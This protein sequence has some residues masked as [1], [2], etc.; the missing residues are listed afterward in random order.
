MCTSLSAHAHA[1]AAQLAKALHQVAID[2]GSWE[3]A[4]LMLPLPDAFQEP[5]FGGS[6]RELAAV[7][8]Y[9]KAMKDLRSKHARL[10]GSDDTEDEETT[11]G[12]AASKAAKKKAALAKKKAAEEAKKAA[13]TAGSGGA[14]GG[15]TGL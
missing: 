9:R 3:S 13:A 2:G 12:P 1:F 5:S 4:S 11:T 7:H 15:K 8:S 14:A 6:E 10:E